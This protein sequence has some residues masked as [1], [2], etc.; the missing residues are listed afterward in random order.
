MGMKKYKLTGQDLTTYNSFK[1]EIGKKQ[2]T[3]GEG[4]LCGP[5]YLHYYHHPLLAVLLNPIHADLKNPKLFEVE[6]G[7]THKDDNGLKGGCTEMTL[8]KEIEL[9]EITTTQR[10]AFSILTSLDVH[11][12]KGYKEWAE[13][14]L[15]GKDRSE[16]A[17]RSAESAAWSAARSAWSAWSAESAWSAA[18]SARSA[19][20][21]ESAAWSAAR[22][23]RS[24]E[25]AARSA[26]SARSAAQIL[27]KLV[28]CAEKC[29]EY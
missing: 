8:V 11:K 20:S 3:S 19:E 6:A 15:S 29:L 13:N 27:E 9:P 5:G 16:S 2:T 12:G 10:V 25:S 17:A 21:A 14:W 24:A 28:E 22:S 26:R 1:W 23:A 4:E 18:R 7:G